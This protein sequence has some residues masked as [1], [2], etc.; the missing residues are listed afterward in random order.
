MSDLLRL[1]AVGAVDDGKSTLIGRLLHDTG[2]IPDDHLEATLIASRK[3]GF[4]ELDLSLLTD[5]LMAEREQG[6]TIDVAYRYFSIPGRKLILAD[7]PGHLQYTR[8][9]ATG[10]STADLALA[11]LDAE[12]GIRDQTKR[13][14]AIAFLFGISQFIVAVNKMDA[15]GYSE[16]AFERIRTE[17]D[18]VSVKLGIAGADL[19]VVPVS[20]LT[21]E[22]V[23]RR[24]GAL[25]WHEGPT[26]LEAL[27]NVA[28]ETTSFN[29]TATARLPVQYVIRRTGSARRY[30]GMVT[31]G[32]LRRGQDVVVLPAGVETRVVRIF[33]PAGELEVAHPL[34]SVSVELEGDVG[35]QR[36]D[37][38]ADGAGAPY[39]TRRFESML[40]WFDS[41]A[42]VAGGGYLVKIGT[43][44]TPARIE[45]VVTSLDI[46]AVAEVPASGLE[47][48][49]IGRVILETSTPVAIDAYGDSRHT[50][51][52]IL[53]DKV[54]HA[55][56]AAGMVRGA[57]AGGAGSL[58]P[59]GSGELAGSG[60]TVRSQVPTASRPAARS[61]T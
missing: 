37:V 30:A 50:G 40:C 49:G 41:L 44:T 8:N 15:V 7:C 3:R 58:T 45:A 36:G 18:S 61:W 53:I 38:I 51:S 46:D 32:I 20:A 42:A 9:M 28:S 27:E 33:G 10:S 59:A 25:A 48:N 57:V 55:T 31:G 35:V 52:F 12:R 2:Q 11:V 5:G 19:T 56:V 21:G 13:H 1:T 29:F 14:L 43:Q 4:D 34:V 22:N 39:V 60:D 6:I 23:V 47:Q 16:Q 54:T 17:L 26:L 24:A